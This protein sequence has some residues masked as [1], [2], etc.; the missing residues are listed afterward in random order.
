VVKQADVCIIGAGPAGYA[1]AISAA[2]QGMKAYVI[3][4]DRV[5][6]TCLNR[7]CIPTKAL[8]QCADALVRAREAGRFGVRIESAPELDFKAAA[9]HR[10]RTTEALASGVEKLLKAWKVEVV[11]GE[12]RLA[13]PGRVVVDTGGGPVEVGAKHIVVATGAEPSGIPGAPI[14]GDRVLSSEGALKLNELPGS[15][16]VIG[17]GVI[18]CEWA[19]LMST[20]GVKVTVIE[21]LPRLLPGEDRATAK[22]VQ[23]V[24]SSRGVEIK[25]GAVVDEV[26]PAGDGV[27]CRL[28]DGSELLADKAIVSV[29]RRPVVEGLGIAEAGVELNGPAV[30]VDPRGRTS[31][32]G[33]WAAGDVIG[34]PMLAHAA[35]H[36]IEVV[37]DN[38]LGG[39][40]E[41]EREVV[42]SVVFIR[43][44]VASVGLLE[45]RAKESGIAV[46]VGRFSYTAS[47][48][49]RCMGETDGFAKVVVEKDGGGLLGGTVMGAHAAELIAELSVAIKSGHT[50]DSFV[51]IIHAHPTL[52]EIL[53]EAVADSRGLATHKVGRRR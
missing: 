24:L 1:G 51:E 25:L 27:R 53:L 37:I 52:S 16:L 32:D 14:D 6:G 30:K 28:G 39:E 44:E 5:G 33:I 7:G 20:F 29:G 12:G 31:A 26:A 46:D 11:G 2:R 21:V 8:R 23:K 36:E 40:R 19:D 45:D 42:P 47:G 3:E 22:A 48:K 34:P 9:E 18:G 4:R 17:G 10:D 15:L 13:G 43:P 49:A 35:A 38:V 41:F 50:V